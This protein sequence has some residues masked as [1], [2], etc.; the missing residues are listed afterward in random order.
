MGMY[1]WAVF[2]LKEWDG[3]IS[4]DGIFYA[5]KP[6]GINYWDSSFN[7]HEDWADQYIEMHCDGVSTL[8]PK[9][10]MVDSLG[11]IAVTFELLTM[12]SPVICTPENKKRITK[13]QKEILFLMFSLR[14]LDM[15]YY[16]VSMGE[17]E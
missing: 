10:Y 15:I 17:S 16:Y 7:I 4:P 2:Y 3:Y 8:C 14:E 6:T 13:E 5:L 12:S 11:W 9:D 1:K